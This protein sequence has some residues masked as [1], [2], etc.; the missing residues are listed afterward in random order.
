MRDDTTLVLGIGAPRAGTTW[1]ATYLNRHPQFYMS[2]LKE[3]HYFDARFLPDTCAYFDH[4]YIHSLLTLGETV[5][6]RDH[7]RMRVDMIEDPRLYLKYFEQY[8]ASERCFG[9]F[10]PAYCLLERTM[11]EEISAMHPSVK[12]I[13]LLRNPVDRFISNAFYMLHSLDIDLGHPDGYILSCLNSR[14]LLVR[15]D[16]RRTMGQYDRA[17]PGQILYLF[18]ERLFCDDTIRR[19]C[20]FC[21]IDFLPGR[22]D[23]RI[24]ASKSAVADRLGPGTRRQV[25]RRLADQYA[26]VRDYFA[27][28]IPE[29]WLADM[30]RYSSPPS[31]RIGV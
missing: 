15:A 24:N 17:A 4:V 5:D 2:P 29:N 11:I 14:H 16:Y 27:G 18:Y 9:E 12:F 22:Y 10:S 13:F 3:L 31:Q 20:E 8:V 26:F 1:L 23:L 28:D 7:I 21:A 19:V 30:A 6:N 25:Y